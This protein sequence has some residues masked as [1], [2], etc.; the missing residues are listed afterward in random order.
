[1]KNKISRN[2]EEELSFAVVD[3]NLLEGKSTSLHNFSLEKE[4]I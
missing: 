1:M 2:Y 4:S 3:K